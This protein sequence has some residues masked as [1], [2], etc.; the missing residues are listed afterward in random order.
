MSLQMLPRQKRFPAL[1][2]RV[3]SCIEVSLVDVPLTVPLASLPHKQTRAQRTGDLVLTQG[4][5]NR[6]RPGD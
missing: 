4:I 1:E 2:T 3:L 5:W 6:D